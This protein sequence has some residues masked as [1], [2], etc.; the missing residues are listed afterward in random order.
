[1]EVFYSQAHTEH[2][3]TTAN[4]PARTHTHADLPLYASKH[5]VANHAESVKTPPSL[6]FG[7][8]V[9]SADV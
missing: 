4:P 3:T 9:K 6:K 8:R 5:Y 1:M 2:D 7:Q